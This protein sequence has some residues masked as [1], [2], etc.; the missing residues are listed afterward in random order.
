MNWPL[1]PRSPT[2]R[3]TKLCLLWD[4]FRARAG[5]MRDRPLLLLPATAQLMVPEL[6]S[7]FWI[8]ASV[9]IMP[10]LRPQSLG[11]SQA[12]ISRARTAPM[13]RLDMALLWR[14]P[15]PVVQAPELITQAPHRELRY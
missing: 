12:S 5:Q 10:S 7:P 9:L 3:R 11:S 2:S 13:I 6:V 8:P 4:T 1:F 15:P 14:P